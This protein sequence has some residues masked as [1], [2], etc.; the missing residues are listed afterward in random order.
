[1]HNRKIDVSSWTNLE[2]V[3]YLLL[4]YKADGQHVY[5]D[6]N[7]HRLYSETVSMDS[8]YKEVSGTT[9]EERDD[10]EQKYEDSFEK[11]NNDKLAREKEYADRVYERNHGKPRNIEKDVVV[12]GL[13]FIA[14]HRDIDQFKLID[15]LLDLGCDFTLKDVKRE[16]PEIDNNDKIGEG[17]KQGD[18]I[19]GA[20]VICFARDTE[21][22]RTYAEE[23]FLRVDNDRS[24]Y[25]FIRK[26]TGDNNYTKENINNGTLNQLK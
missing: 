24:V 10:S 13:K 4:A 22:G 1:M 14:E 11:K 2:S 12:N 23:N 26:V 17:L 3:V 5:C 16:S 18:I 6:Y 21:Y 20:E 19:R 25:E 15:A 8:A 7:G 9:K